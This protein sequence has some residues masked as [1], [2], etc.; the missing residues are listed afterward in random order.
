LSVAVVNEVQ[1]TTE[2]PGVE[3][4]HHRAAGRETHDNCSEEDSGTG[5][6]I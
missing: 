6:L 2:R 3:E 1:G 4:I 5:E